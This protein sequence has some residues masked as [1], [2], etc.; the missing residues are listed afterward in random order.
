MI[1]INDTRRGQKNV[2]DK[3]E[4]PAEPTQTTPKGV[5]IPIPK[6]DDVLRDLKKISAPESERE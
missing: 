6:R 5:E 2:R 4:R 3:A 1:A